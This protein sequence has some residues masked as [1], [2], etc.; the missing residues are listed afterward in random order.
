MLF[1]TKRVH[2]DDEVYMES[3][4]EKRMHFLFILL[5]YCLSVNMML[6][7]HGSSPYYLV[8]KSLTTKTGFLVVWYPSSNQVRNA[9]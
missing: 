9:V 7:V 2:G 4:E 6:Q 8:T 1:N 3:P 5:I